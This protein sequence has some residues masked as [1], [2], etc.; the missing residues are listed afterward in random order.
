MP[1][2]KDSPSK[3]VQTIQTQTAVNNSPTIANF[4]AT[5]VITQ[6]RVNQIVTQAINY[7]RQ[8]E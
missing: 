2:G 7:L 5:S 1:Q 8:G 4:I 6:A 3:A